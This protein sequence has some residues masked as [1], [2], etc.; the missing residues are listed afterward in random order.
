MIGYCGNSKEVFTDGI[1]DKET[2]AKKCENG[3]T[4]YQTYQVAESHT[5]KSVAIDK[6]LQ[7]YKSI[8]DTN[9]FKQIVQGLM[10]GINK[11]IRFLRSSTAPRMR[12]KTVGGHS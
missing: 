7:K 10:D 3:H 5:E 11:Y 8:K 4:I 6:A 9:Q 2:W 12:T 1:H